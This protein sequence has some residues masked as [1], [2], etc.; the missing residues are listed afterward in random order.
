M[1]LCMI[2]IQKHSIAYSFLAEPTQYW[3]FH[4]GR[5]E[6]VSHKAV[7]IVRPFP[8][9]RGPCTITLIL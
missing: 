7:Y 8:A 2:L 3:N 9:L 6:L 5:A 1:I 4:Q